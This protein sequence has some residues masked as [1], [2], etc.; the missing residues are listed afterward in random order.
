[1][2]LK[3]ILTSALGAGILSLGLGL[4]Q[5]QT[6]NYAGPASG[7][8]WNT[9]ANWDVL[10]PPGV[11]TNVY[12]G[13]STNVNYNTPMSAASFGGLT[14]NGILNINAGGF[15]CG[16]V[17]MV[18]PASQRLFINNGGAV[19]VSG[20][21]T[22]STNANVTL[23]AGGS[24]TV[25]GTLTLAFGE[26]TKAPASFSTL[27]NNG[28][29][30]TANA[31]TINNNTGTGN[32]LLVVNG[33]TNYLGNTIIGRSAAGAGGQTLGLDGL[34]VYG[35]QVVT[36]N[37]NIGNSGTA[38]SAVAAYVAGG[39]VTNFGNVTISQLTA[40]RLSR[41][42]Q[43]GGLFVTPDPGI[44][45][46]NGTVAT[47]ISIYAVLG[48]TNIVGGFF[49]GNSNSSVTTINFTNSSTLY[50]GSQGINSNGAALVT[51]VLNGGGLLGA[52]APWTSTVGMKLNNGIFTFQTADAA[53]NPNNITYTAPLTGAGGLNATGNGIL[54]LGGANTYTGN[55]T[56]SGGKLALS[57]GTSLT[58]LRIQIGSGTTFDVSQDT[59][60]TLAG[61][62]TLFGFGT[63]AG[64][65]T[66]ASGATIFPGS[67][68]VTGTLTMQ[69]GLTETGG[70]INTFNL[71]SNPT[72]PGND[73]LNV[74]G[75]LGLSGNNTVVISGSLLNGGVYP[76]IAYNGNLT[77][78][79]ANL[80]VSG[81]TGVFSNSVANSIIYFI[82]QST[83]RG[84]TNV[85]WIGNP[86]ANTWDTENTT[87]WLNPGTA[88]LDF[89]VP[90]DVALFNNVGATNPL[91][92]LTVTNIPGGVIV[93]TTSNYT[94]LGNG[95]IG[96]LG[97]VTVSNGT[98]NILTTN[99][100]TGATIIDGGLLS[101]PLIA[102]SGSPSGIGAAS[103]DPANLVINGG[104]FGYT[105]PSAGTDHGITLANSG[106]T[107]DVTNGS[108][109]ALNGVIGG[110]GGLTLVDSGTLNLTA[111]NTYNGNTTVSNGT[112]IVNNVTGVGAGTVNLNGGILALGAVK[113]A[114]IIN[115]NGGSVSGGN[116]GGLTGIKN[117][118]GSSNLVVSV[119]TSNGTFD[120]VGD[121]TAYTGT[122]ILSNANTG[123]AFVRL[124]T[125][126]T[127]IPDGSASATFDL[128]ADGPLALDLNIRT[129]TL[130]NN[131]GALKGSTNT[132]LS[133]RGGSSNN[134]STTHFIGAN[135]L[136]TTFNGVIQ[137]GS[138]GTASTTAINKVGTGTLSLTGPSTYTGTT[139]VSTGI[140]ALVNSPFT[141]LDGSING[142]ATINVLAGAILSGTG[143]SDGAVPVGA[144]GNQVLEGNGNVQGILSLN[145][146]GT[147]SPGGG[148]KG[149]IGTLTASSINL[150]AGGTTLM[151][152]NR[153]GTQKSD[154]LVS[155]GVFNAGGTL[156]VTNIGAALQVNDTFTLFSSGS[157]PTGGFNLVLPGFYTWDTSQLMINGSIKVTAVFKPAI[158]SVDTS[159]LASGGVI[160]LTATNG[161]P[162]AIVNVLTSTNLSQPFSSWTVNTQFQLDDSGNL[163]SVPISVDQT[164]PQ[165]FIILQGF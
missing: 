127:T 84:P 135:N 9:A 48:G 165:L 154:K 85:T 5:A 108:T 71:S 49:L 66:A 163:G 42:V 80:T 103:T 21:M 40:A 159:S 124:N 137:N 8:D 67:N 160:F 162:D 57:A 14:N 97:G 32:G 25:N 47:T 105:G 83:V 54:T 109:L 153:N 28:G 114:N 69:N 139:T 125:S 93:N 131:F 98:V 129:S 96:G 136:S 39:T 157:A 2:Q 3:T 11:G 110:N 147:I 41:F 90:G 88:A 62:Q 29:I 86:T 101:T 77:G 68:S 119:T 150:A 142:S 33:G 144:T 138:G 158:S 89:F 58:S 106:G 149:A 146:S 81:V 26:T 145:G 128:E 55:T 65:V 23:A 156:Q 92:N 134:G 152:L 44:V 75:G 19:V 45:N 37:L 51:A 16:P 82:S 59:G 151:K 43:S 10:L 123:S 115:A 63:V 122:L 30:L 161:Q 60:Y 141:G 107:F 4:G 6:A 148:P 7:G 113:P 27:T 22:L 120:L 116:A 126:S 50:V 13:V 36:T 132:T 12:I 164:Q 102:N 99:I 74:S 76:L 20:N 52:T 121:L 94:L 31:T 130:T 87:N 24:L 34:V 53:G 112:L 1:M 79:I 72:G 104:A 17:F 143:R 73:F 35:G 78:G 100:Y 155:L 18:S 46:P 38:P 61:T 70:V 15:N 111:A 118:I 133:G 56:I 64:A 91:V 140:L 95:A 117:V